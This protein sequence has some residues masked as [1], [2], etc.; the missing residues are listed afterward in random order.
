MDKPSLKNPTKKGF[1]DDKNKS[2]LEGN[3][4]G[5]LT[6]KDSKSFGSNVLK[7]LA[8]VKFNPSYKYSTKVYSNTNMIVKDQHI[9]D[10]KND[11]ITVVTP[12]KTPQVKS[13]ENIIRNVNQNKSSSNTNTITITSSNTLK[14][15]ISKFI[16]DK[17]PEKISKIDSTA[18]NNNKQETFI[19]NKKSEKILPT[20]VLSDKKYLSP[21]N[22]DSSYNKII[23]L[24]KIQ[25]EKENVDLSNNHPTIKNNN[26][27]DHTN[28]D[29]YTDNNNDEDLENLKNLIFKKEKSLE[30]KKKVRNK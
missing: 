29:D 20:Y 21:I 1:F 2:N 18:I 10:V 12:H 25:K 17:D 11:Q 16:V 22:K 24:S 8:K 7:N 30:Y 19:D 6:S 9:N 26:L 13:N 27:N 3:N 4:L 15:Q 28:E 5:S 14:S 23:E